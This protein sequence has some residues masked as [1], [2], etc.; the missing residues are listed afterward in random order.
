MWSGNSLQQLCILP[1]DVV[2]L[3]VCHQ[4]D[5]CKKYVGRVYVGGYD[6][7]SVGGLCVFREMCPVG[8]L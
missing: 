7:M 5:V 4:D 6:G 8:F 2:C 3:S 1:F